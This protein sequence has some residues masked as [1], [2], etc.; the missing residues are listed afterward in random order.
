MAPDP[1]NRI[2]VSVFMERSLKPNGMFNSQFVRINLFVEELSTKDKAEIAGFLEELSENIETYPKETI[3]YKF[4]PELIK[5]M[6]YGGDVSILTNILRISKTMNDEE[7]NDIMTPAIIGFYQSNDRMLRYNLL[8][9][10]SEYIN[11]LPQSVVIK[12]IFPSYLSGF[13]DNAPAIRE[14]T[15][16]SLP[17]FIPILPEKVVNSD[18]IRHLTRLISDTEPG[19]RAN[20]LICIGKVTKKHKKYGHSCIN[21]ILKR[22]I[23]TIQDSIF[24]D[25]N[26]PVRDISSKAV[27]ALLATVE[28][29]SKT[30]PDTAMVQKSGPKV[31]KGSQ[32][33]Q[34][35]NNQQGGETK[36]GWMIST[37]ASGISGA[38]TYTT[39]L[40]K[41]E[42]LTSNEGS[43]NGSQ[44]ITGTNNSN[45][46]RNSLDFKSK[47]S[48]TKDTN[49]LRN[50]NQTPS[51]LDAHHRSNDYEVND[52]WENEEFGDFLRDT[53]SGHT[54]QAG[55]GS[56][57]FEFNSFTNSDKPLPYISN[58]DLKEE[59][60]HDFGDSD[61]VKE[62]PIKKDLDNHDDG[63]DFK[64]NDSSND[65]D[66]DPS[67]WNFNFNSIND[68]NQPQKKS[69]E[70][71]KNKSQ[72]LPSNTS[73]NSPS[74]TQSP[75]VVNNLKSAKLLT[76]IY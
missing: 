21:N 32:D 67:D 54:K 42:N 46:A 44:N 16:K 33:T 36:G 26:G 1:K 35:V 57:D 41:S 30:L 24:K 75:K 72:I 29:F 31:A 34:T 53:D 25:H 18:L 22:P 76:K 59:P 66:A 69:L 7:Y 70:N 15:V 2:P 65:W 14:E 50:S 9:S 10:I 68:S 62:Y 27:V 19:I 17:L 20:S 47:E 12:N 40:S 4:L 61:F 3:K 38:L 52:G 43:V 49:Q 56:N 13:Q 74:G 45:S 37:L 64:I 51:N 11:L 8:K 58:I 39:S 55:W 6:G 63:S 48:I 71:E 73:M 23:P 28:E 5:I 60:F